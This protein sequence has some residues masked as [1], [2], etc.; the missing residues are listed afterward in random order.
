MT[1]TGVIIKALAQ[2]FS[3][4]N[5]NAMNLAHNNTCTYCDVFAG[6]AGT[7]VLLPSGLGRL[8]RNCIAGNSFSS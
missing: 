2:S 6:I 5:Y 4:V 8:L 1:R 3:A 7:R